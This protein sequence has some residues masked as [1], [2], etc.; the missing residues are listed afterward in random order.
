M[1]PSKLLPFVL[2]VWGFSTSIP[3]ADKPERKLEEEFHVSPK[4]VR[5]KAFNETEYSLCVC[6]GRYRY[7]QNVVLAVMPV[8]SHDCCPG[9][10][11][12][13]LAE[14]PGLA[15]ARARFEGDIQ[16]RLVLDGEK[17]VFEVKPSA[18]FRLVGT[19]S[20][21]E[22]QW[23]S[24]CVATIRQDSF[25]RNGVKPKPSR[26]LVF[27]KKRS[28]I[29]NGAQVVYADSIQEAWNKRIELEKPTCLEDA[30]SLPPTNP[31]GSD[32]PDRVMDEEFRI[33][34]KV[35]HIKAFNG[36][37][38][39]LC[40]S[41]YCRKSDR[42]I[43]IGILPL[44]RDSCCSDNPEVYHKPSS[45]ITIVKA[46]FEGDIHERLVVDSEK[47]VY[48]G[49]PGAV[50]VSVGKNSKGEEQWDSFC[51]ATIEQDPKSLN[52]AKPKP[53]RLLVFRKQ[54]AEIV[55]GAQVVYADGIQEAWNKRI[56]LEKPKCLEDAG[57]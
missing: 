3:G 49:H 17:W 30:D 9:D 35:V 16:E 53:S 22:E 54:K 7:S 8:A 11:D 38:Y 28:E 40:I 52:G 26:L 4:I 19:N 36:T 6:A 29:V 14:S 24:F 45:T 50:Y 21:G 20:K 55:N 56:E 46:K 34:P 44:G 31:A 2:I 37:N 39:S 57:R 32:K 13:Y 47:W 12:A 15:I 1:R 41:S 42:Q 27:H 33:L 25:S 51:V 48:E 18:V 23:D 43:E 5:I 10:P